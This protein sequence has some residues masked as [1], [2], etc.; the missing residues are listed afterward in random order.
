[1][2]N[3]DAFMT[4]GEIAHGLHHK[5]FSAVEIATL[6]LERMRCANDKLHA[7]VSIDEG[8]VLAQARA[9]DERRARGLNLSDLDGVP[10]AAKDL[11]D[12]EG[13]VTTAGSQAWVDRRS[14]GTC[15]ALRKC[16]QAGMVLLGKTHMVEFALGSWGT[17]PVMGT[18]WNPWDLSTHRVPGGSSSGS[19]VAVAAGLAPAAIGSDTGGS[20]RIPAA[21]NG[22]TGLKTTRGLISLHGA[23][24]LSC[25]LDTIGPMVHSAEDAAIW[26]DIMAGA[27]PQDPSSWHHPRFEWTSDTSNKAATHQSSLTGV[28]LAVLP[29]DQYPWTVDPEALA[30]FEQACKVWQD[31]GAVLETLPLPFDFHDLM[32]RNGQIIAA[33]AYAMHQAYIEDEAL[34][35][36]QFVRQRI[37]G[38]KGLSAADYINAITHHRTCSQTFTGLMQGFAALVTPTLPFPAVPLA[39]VDEAQTPMSSFCRA[40]NYLTGCALALPAGLSKQGLPLSIQLIGKS[41]GEADVLRLGVSL[42]SVTDWHRLRPDLSE[43]GL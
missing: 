11:C 33:E 7:Y 4:M 37:L 19:G 26:T 14:Q 41:F 39:E 8:A 2:S 18:P 6:Y 1:M 32:V 12:I 5:T 38:G 42:Q 23:V 22:I 24:A 31:L 15:T 13:H 40:G 3:Q 43:L 25:T 34:P 35:L 30:A 10:F 16:L 27:D 28:K 29:P 21:L 17:N 20:V 36:G 9:A